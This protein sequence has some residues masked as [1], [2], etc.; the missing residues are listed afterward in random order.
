MIR[1]VCPSLPVRACLRSE[2]LAGVESDQSL[3]KG[4]LAA[5]NDT[6]TQVRARLGGVESPPEPPSGTPLGSGG[7][8]GF[9]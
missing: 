8:C 1:S 7:T 5:T 6:L 4:L 3:L 9:E 2:R